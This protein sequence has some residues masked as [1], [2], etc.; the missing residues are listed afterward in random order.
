MPMMHAGARI[1]VHASCRGTHKVQWFNM[2]A[3]TMKRLRTTKVMGMM[4]FGCA[5]DDG[6]KEME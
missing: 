5:Y 1:K 6:G 2:Y 3:E 4:M